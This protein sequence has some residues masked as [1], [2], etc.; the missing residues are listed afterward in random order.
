MTSN[1][2]LRDGPGKFHEIDSIVDYRDVSYRR[3]TVMGVDAASFQLEM[4]CECCDGR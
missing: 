3:N 4:S 1:M 2:T